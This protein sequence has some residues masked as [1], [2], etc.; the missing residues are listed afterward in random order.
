M[1]PKRPRED[2]LL[3]DDLRRPLDAMLPTQPARLADERLLLQLAVGAAS[4]RLY[5]SY[6]RIDLAESRARVPSFYAL[7]L[8]RAATGR[9]PDHELLAEQAR[10]AGHASLAWPAPDRPEDA[11]DDQEHDLAVLRGLLDHPDPNAVKG[12]AHYLL[13][14]N[15]ALR[16]SVVDRWSRGQPRWS[17]GDGLTR[18]VPSITA[19]LEAERPGARAYSASALQKFSACPY[20]FVLSAIH[21]LQRLERP[22]PLQRMDP[23][24]RGSIFHRMQAEFFRAMTARGGL[25]VTMENRAIAAQVLDETCAHVAADERDQLAPAVERVW[26]DE[27]GSIRRDLHAWLDCL[28]ADGLEWTPLYFE[29]AFGRVP[30]ERDPNSVR[31]DVIIGDRYRMRG[32]ID[33]IE[34]H[35]QTGVLRVTDH[36]TG[37]APDRLERT[38]VGGGAVLQPVLYGMAAE[39]ALGTAVGSSRLFYCTAAGG[40][41]AHLVPINDATRASGL[42]VLEIIDRAI[43][44]AFLVAAPTE[45]A[46]GRCDFRQICGRHAN[47]R[48]RRKP[49]DALADLIAL[50]R[51]P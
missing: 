23:L 19:A 51:M 28:S 14:L 31:D 21:R 7:D 41:R 40:F 26:T 32:A 49:Q 9:L 27:I 15:D 16:R 45:E 3:L 29:L 22:E 46:C 33:L 24:T 20:Q 47:R 10:E 42:E 35:R 1:F 48:A 2:P 43:A 17:S 38:L 37:R 6:P 18:A 8:M 36:K 34:R 44:S 4:E 13:G 11:I 30:G 5:V 50:R 12:H 25:P 39:A